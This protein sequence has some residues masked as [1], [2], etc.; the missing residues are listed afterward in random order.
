MIDDLQ[1]L[2]SSKFA[3]S[4]IDKMEK[5]SVG[6]TCPV[7]PRLD[8]DFIPKSVSEMRKEAPAKPM[9]IGCC[10]S[11]GLTFLG[12]EKHP[13]LSTIMEQISRL[14]PEKHQPRLFEKLR[15]EVFEK[16]AVNPQ[17]PVIVAR[18]FTE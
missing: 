3:L 7:G 14:I 4:L 6:N 9:L 15:E 2:P 10:A 16:L 11:E 18:A 1:R 12:F 5:S 17:N 13:S 8:F